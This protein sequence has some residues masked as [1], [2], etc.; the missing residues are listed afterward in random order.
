MESFFDVAGMLA[1]GVGLGAVIAFLFENVGWFQELPSNIKW[2]VILCLS[3]ALPVLAQLAVQ[4]VPADVWALLEPYWQA[5][6]AGFLVWAGSQGTHLLAN[7]R[8]GGC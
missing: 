3:L 2:W 6:A 8:A 5:L 1:R 7:K 4:L